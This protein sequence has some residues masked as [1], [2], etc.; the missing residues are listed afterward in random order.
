[1]IEI[2]IRITL[3]LIP[4]YITNASAL[5]FGGERPLDFNIK[6]LGAPIFGKGKTFEGTFAGIAMGLLSVFI[7]FTFFPA[8]TG[9]LG[10]NF[11]VFGSLLCIGAMFGDLLGSFI[12]RRSGIPRGGRVFLL[13]QLDFVFGGLLLTYWLIEPAWEELVLIIGITL[14]AHCFSNYCAY[15]LKMKSVSW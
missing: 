11:L 12:K 7:L 3:Y 5:V 4:L 9:L 2:L 13:D 8:Q 14:L 6:L 10:E 15:K 1:M